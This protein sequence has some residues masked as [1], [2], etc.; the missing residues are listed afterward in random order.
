MEVGI[1]GNSNQDTCKFVLKDGAYCTNSG[2]KCSKH[3]QWKTFKKMKCPKSPSDPECSE[4]PSE[5]EISVLNQHKGTKWICKNG[6]CV[7]D[8]TTGCRGSAKCINGA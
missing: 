7:L 2:A 3:G 8:R 6:S 4:F 5:E 1:S